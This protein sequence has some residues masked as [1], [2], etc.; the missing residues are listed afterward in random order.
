MIF[1]VLSIYAALH[2]LGK[3]TNVGEVQSKMADEKRTTFALI[4]HC[5]KNIST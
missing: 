4:G 3:N 2:N 5:L 1:D